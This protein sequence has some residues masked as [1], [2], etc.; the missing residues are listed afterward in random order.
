[1]AHT[2]NGAE[3]AAGAAEEG[4]EKIAAIRTEEV[5]LKAEERKRRSRRPRKRRR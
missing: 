4:A 2:A 1:M 3:E 5:R